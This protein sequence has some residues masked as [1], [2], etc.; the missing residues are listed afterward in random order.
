MAKQSVINRNLKRITT[1]DRKSKARSALIEK[2]DEAIKLIAQAGVDNKLS[3]QAKKDLRE[4]MNK[5]DKM[6]RDSSKS[7]LRNRCNNCGR[8]RGTYRTFGYCR[9]CLR[10]W[11]AQGLLPG[12]KK[13]SW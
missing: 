7:R 12:V 13:S 4:A 1:V 8:P 3:T 9:M 11:H 6:P 10:T 5:L 2:R